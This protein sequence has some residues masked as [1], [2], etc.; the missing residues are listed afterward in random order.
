MFAQLL[1][2]HGCSIEK[3]KSNLVECTTHS[4][5]KP[6]THWHYFTRYIK[7]QSGECSASQHRAQGRGVGAQR[8]AMLQ[9]RFVSVSQ[10]RIRC[11]LAI[12]KGRH[13]Q[14]PD[15]HS[16]HS[17]Q[18]QLLDIITA[19][20]QVYWSAHT[21]AQRLWQHSKC[22]RGPNIAHSAVAP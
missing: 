12:A 10:Q 8:A 13:G 3:T 5:A 17:V 21:T 19:D 18:G 16:R 15:T 6:S 22:A 2:P 9:K 7:D 20:E 14:L 1:A 11:H 4:N